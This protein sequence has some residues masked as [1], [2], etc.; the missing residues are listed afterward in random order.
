MLFFCP[1]QVLAAL[2]P[3]PE[4]LQLFA[5]ELLSEYE[6]HGPQPDARTAKITLS[7]LY[8]RAPAQAVF[9]RESGA[10]VLVKVVTVR[11]RQG[12]S[13]SEEFYC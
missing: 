10:W 11:E 13:I 12:R 7:G 8:G 5:A 2:M 9:K 1:F 4:S 3:I 6:R